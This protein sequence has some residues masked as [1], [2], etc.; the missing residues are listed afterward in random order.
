[1]ERGIYRTWDHPISSASISRRYVRTVLEK[2]NKNRVTQCVPQ[3]HNPAVGTAE[4]QN[5]CLHTDVPEH[6]IKWSSSSREAEKFDKIPSPCRSAFLSSDY[7]YK[8]IPFRFYSEGSLEELSLTFQEVNSRN[9]DFCPACPCVFVTL[10]LKM[11]PAEQRIERLCLL[12]DRDSD[13]IKCQTAANLIETRELR[14]E[15]R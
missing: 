9:L 1:M 2:H 15:E 8:L 10:S 3:W 13:P 5:V 12:A 6:E 7:S 11:A 4:L 14:L